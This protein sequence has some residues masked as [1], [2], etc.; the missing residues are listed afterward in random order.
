[1]RL[2]AKN[3]Y[4]QDQNK[5]EVVLRGSKLRLAFNED[6]MQLKFISDKKNPPEFTISY[7]EAI[8]I[9]NVLTWCRKNNIAPNITYI[10]NTSEIRVSVLDDEG[11]EHPI[12]YN[13]IQNEIGIMTRNESGYPLLITEKNI[14]DYI[15]ENIN[16]DDIKVFRDRDLGH[17]LLV[18]RPEAKITEIPFY[19]VPYILGSL[20]IGANYDI[21]VDRINKY[22]ERN[23]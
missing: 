19:T 3:F 15:E 20:N 16:A 18:Y 4:L 2:S 10:C 6:R 23:L 21:L 12:A 1:M 13:D 5:D 14:V 8:D 9:I 17:W 7:S 11:K 22:K